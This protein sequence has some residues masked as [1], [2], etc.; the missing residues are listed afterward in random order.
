MKL[1]GGIVM[2]FLFFKLQYMVREFNSLYLKYISF[3]KGF[4]EDDYVLQ[5]DWCFR[6]GIIYVD[7]FYFCYFI[8]F[9]SKI[10]VLNCVFF[11]CI[12]WVQK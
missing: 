4:V 5:V 10:G 3:L 12:F 7:G 8:S 2:F 11:L 9:G 1:V 6:K